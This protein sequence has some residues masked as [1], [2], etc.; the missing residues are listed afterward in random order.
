LHQEYFV[1]HHLPVKLLAGLVLAGLHNS[2]L[3]SYHPKL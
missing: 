2:S 3:G 1:F